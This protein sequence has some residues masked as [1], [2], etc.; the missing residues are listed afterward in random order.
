MRFVCVSFVTKHYKKQRLDFCFFS[1]VKFLI[2]PFKTLSGT[3][4]CLNYFALDIH[5]LGLKGLGFAS[6]KGLTKA[7]NSS[8]NLN[9]GWASSHIKWWCCCLV[10]NFAK[11]SFLYFW[12]FIIFLSSFFFFEK[13]NKLLTNFGAYFLQ[14]LFFKKLDKAFGILWEFFSFQK[15]FIS[16]WSL[17]NW[18]KPLASCGFFLGL[19]IDIRFSISAFFGFLKVD[20][21]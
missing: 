19:K 14:L 21:L 17:K 11:Y 15:Y 8:S 1:H 5:L 10:L 18:R 4:S 3:S 2:W 13:L 12:V 6:S 7:I 9:W 20:V 16:T